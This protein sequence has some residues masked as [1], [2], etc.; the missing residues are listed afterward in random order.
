MNEPESSPGAPAVAPRI[1]VVVCTYNRADR[2]P[3]CLASLTVQDLPH[4][5]WE[6]I[7]IDDGSTDTTPTVCAQFAHL[8]NLRVIRQANAG[9][10]AARERG[11]RATTAPV[12]GFLDD[13]AVAPPGWLRLAVDHFASAAPLAACLGGPTR[14]QWEIPPPAWLDAGLSLYLT[15]WAPYAERRE[16]ATDHLFVGANMFFRRAALE[17]VHGFDAG[18]GRRGASLLSHEES[19]LWDRLRAAG[20]R[21]VYEPSLWVFHYVPAARLTPAWFRRRIYWEGVSIA[22]RA[23]LPR[24]PLRGLR[25]MVFALVDRPVLSHL[26]HPARWGRSLA[27]Q[28][29]IAY[30]WGYARELFR[31][32]PPPPS[33]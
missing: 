20:Y 23:R 16:S 28:C 19:D 26:A 33:P 31:G 17:A 25:L 6:I 29:H 14:G 7:V 12:V 22:R 10:G 3:A 8:P 30:Q 9:L 27:W 2:L 4:S 15:V 11:W 1:A 13:D 18:L 21:G 5:D 32:S 24:R